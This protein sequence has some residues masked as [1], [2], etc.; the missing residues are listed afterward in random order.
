MLLINTVSEAR[1]ALDPI[2]NGGQP[3]AFVPTMGALHEGHLALVRRARETHH[4]VVC[5][6]FVNPAQFNDP[7]D[8]RR[9]PVSLDQDLALLEREGVAFAFHPSTQ[10]IYPDGIRPELDYPLGRLDHILEG[11]YRPGHFQGVARVMERLLEIV[12]P[13]SLFMGQKD[14]Q[15]CLVIKKL[16]SWLQIS[17]EFI[18]CP[19]LREPDGL[20]LSSRNLLLD[21]G[22]RSK[23]PQLYEALC[24]TRDRVR[25]LS[26]TQIRNRAVQRLQAAG[27]Q[28][29]YLEL[30]DRENLEPLPR[31]LGSPMVILAAGK[32]GGIRLIDNVIAG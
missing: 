18:Q 4:P 1:S 5:S 27:F 32:I 10:E 7:E 19:T 2:R 3:L 28:V 16:L 6:I 8:F 9:Y 21:P 13:G 20:A 31:F 22:S 17:L 23:A 11:K 14:Y 24:W 29:D 25:R 26:F 30:A 12:R 15:Q